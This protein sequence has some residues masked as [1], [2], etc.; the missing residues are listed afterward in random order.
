MIA[1]RTGRC[2]GG[3]AVG[4]TVEPGEKLA[5]AGLHRLRL[6]RILVIHAQDV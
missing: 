6:V 3:T 2:A 5:L 4:G 1:C